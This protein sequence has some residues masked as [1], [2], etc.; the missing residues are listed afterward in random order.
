MRI[1]YITLIQQIPA[2]YVFE[3]HRENGIM[4]DIRVKNEDFHAYMLEVNF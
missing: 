3:Q 1:A 2:V 4:D